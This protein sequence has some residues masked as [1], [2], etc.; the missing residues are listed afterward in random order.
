MPLYN[1][2][3]G[4]IPSCNFLPSKRFLWMPKKKNEQTL[5]F[6]LQEE[7]TDDSKQACLGKIIFNVLAQF[8]SKFEKG[9]NCLIA[10]NIPTGNINPRFQNVEI[11]SRWDK[12]LSFQY[13]DK[14]LSQKS[15]LQSLYKIT[16]IRSRYCSCPSHHPLSSLPVLSLDLLC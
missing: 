14:F 4:K 7:S 9:G 13:L 16:F 8:F 15:I 11:I 1:F 10:G 5:L 2:E 12:L 6:L 3:R